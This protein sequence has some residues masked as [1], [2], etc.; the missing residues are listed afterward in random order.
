[1]A[2]LSGASLEIERH[3]LDLAPPD[4][5]RVSASP[6]RRLPLSGTLRQGALLAWIPFAFSFGPPSRLRESRRWQRLCSMRSNGNDSSE[7]TGPKSFKA[8]FCEHFHCPPERYEDAL[9]WRCLF[10][11]ALPVAFLIR[12]FDPGYF[13]EDMDLIREVGATTSQQLFKNEI[14]YFFGRNLRDKSWL[15]N[16]FKIRVSGNRLIHLRRRLLLS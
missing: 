7:G 1:M 14:N 8:A 6:R 10:R 16:T 9:F 4:P 13:T 12:R 5:L 3:V 11:H 2:R 15:R